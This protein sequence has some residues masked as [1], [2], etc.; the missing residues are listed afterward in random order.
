MAGPE[1]HPLNTEPP[2]PWGPPEATG[3]HGLVINRALSRCSLGMSP[4]D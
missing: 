1:K 4:Y 3:N 2:T